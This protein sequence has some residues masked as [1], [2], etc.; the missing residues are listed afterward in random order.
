MN[1]RKIGKTDRKKGKTYPVY[2]DEFW[3]VDFSQA[4]MENW[5]DKVNI[6]VS[7]VAGFTLAFV[8]TCLDEPD[9][10]TNAFRTLHH[11]AAPRN[12]INSQTRFIGVLLD[13]PFITSL[14]KCRYWAGITIP[15]G[16][17]PGKEI[18]VTEMKSGVH[19]TFSLKGNLQTTLKNL[20][21]FNHGWL[22]NA[23]YMIKDLTGYEEF[24]ENPTFKPVEQIERRLFVPVKTA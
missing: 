9:A 2:T 1:I 3:P 16:I 18:S 12:F 22:K 15:T 4:E 24:S 7:K 19:A 17:N 14:D 13:I 20:I 21:I 8:S 5:K 11:W 6:E 23:G 10:I